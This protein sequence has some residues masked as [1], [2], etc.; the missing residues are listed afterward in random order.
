MVNIDLKDKPEWYLQINP[1]GKVPLLEEDKRV[2]EST[3]CAQYLDD[4]FNGRN[5]LLPAAHP[6]Q[7]AQQKM[8]VEVIHGK[9]ATPHMQLILKG[10]D[11]QNREALAKALD[12][13]E[14]M[15]VGPYLSG[16]R[17][18]QHRQCQKFR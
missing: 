4:K 6:L 8:M 3:N 16:K 12:E 5:P 14:A 17:S 11:E 7:R 15:L 2:F 13:I 10:A 1:L 9:I 18:L